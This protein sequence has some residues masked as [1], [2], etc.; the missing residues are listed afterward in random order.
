MRAL[1]GKGQQEL[2]HQYMQDELLTNH[3]TKEAA[4]RDLVAAAVVGGALIR[5][6]LPTGA[7]TF[8]PAA[9]NHMF[10]ALDVRAGPARPRVP[11][12]GVQWAGVACSGPACC[13][14]LPVGAVRL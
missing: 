9:H 14:L 12:A 1:Q 11:W 4:S 2:V 10:V 8:R 6:V 7:F 13:G 5:V 3:V